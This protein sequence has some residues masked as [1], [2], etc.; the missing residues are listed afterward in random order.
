VGKVVGK[1][2]GTDVGIGEGREVGTDVFGQKLRLVTVML[3]SLPKSTQWP[4]Q[5]SNPI[6]CHITLLGILADSIASS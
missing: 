1:S 2:V 6:V 3:T 4:I 5:L